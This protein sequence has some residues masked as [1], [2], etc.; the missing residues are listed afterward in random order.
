MTPGKLVFFLLMCL[1]KLNEE[2]LDDMGGVYVVRSPL[3]TMVLGS[4]PGPVI[5]E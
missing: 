2:V 3:T 5:C 4:I 1:Q